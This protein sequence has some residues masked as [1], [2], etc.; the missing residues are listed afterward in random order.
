MQGGRGNKRAI[1]LRN[2]QI[3]VHLEKLPVNKAHS[4]C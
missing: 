1:L 4:T 3:M 2:E